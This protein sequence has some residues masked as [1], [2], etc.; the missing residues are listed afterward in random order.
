MQDLRPSAVQQV[1]VSV[2]S[3]VWM[4]FDPVTVPVTIVALPPQ[5]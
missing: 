2:G 3:P 5:R 1:P 4:T